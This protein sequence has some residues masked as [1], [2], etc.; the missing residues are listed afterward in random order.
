MEGTRQKTKRG[1]RKKKN[2]SDDRDD[3]SSTTSTNPPKPNQAPMSKMFKLGDKELS[4]FDQ[5]VLTRMGPSP[6]PI[7]V[8]FDQIQK[9]KKSRGPVKN[10]VHFMRYL[11][12]QDHLFVVTDEKTVDSKLSIQ[13][14]QNIKI[15]ALNAIVDAHPRASNM[16]VYDKGGD[17][18]SMTVLFKATQIDLTDFVDVKEFFVVPDHGVNR[19]KF[20]EKFN[21]DELCFKLIKFLLKSSKESESFH[22]FYYSEKFISQQFK[23]SVS[24]DDTKNKNLLAAIIDLC[25]FF[26][27]KD[28]SSSKIKLN[29]EHEE[30]TTGRIYIEVMR[31]VENSFPTTLK[32]IYAKL[33]NF[34]KNESSTFEKFKELCQDFAPLNQELKWT[35]SNNIRLIQHIRNTT[36]NR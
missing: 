21:V 31:I 9:F 28:G 5:T 16:T 3:N 17:S 36:P 30:L 22:R 32:T 8:L 33:P 7:D 29:C 19:R 24:E 35:M 13:D 1:G 6:W 25:P 14:H 11:K 34:L 12:N 26:F 4:L 15:H 27:T 23:T 18:K 2:K 10:L 20:V